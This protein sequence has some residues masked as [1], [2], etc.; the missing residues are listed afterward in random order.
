M[1]LDAITGTIAEVVAYVIGKITGRALKL[2]PKQAQRVGEY[3]VIAVVLGA[4]VLVTL[5]YS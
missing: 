2:D 4:G 5:I 3:A 1:A